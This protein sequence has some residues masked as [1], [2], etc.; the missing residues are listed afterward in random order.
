LG[1]S[2]HAPAGKLGSSSAGL[3]R[4]PLASVA[5][6]CGSGCNSGVSGEDRPNG[7]QGESCAG[8]RGLGEGVT[9]ADVVKWLQVAARG[10]DERRT[11]GG[12]QR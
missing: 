12:C 8:P 9:N 4:D 10:R 11:A 7:F 3:G 5:S 1:L 2:H 6:S